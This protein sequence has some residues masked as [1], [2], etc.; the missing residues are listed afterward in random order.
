M[1]VKFKFN[2]KFIFL[3]IFA[4][5]R[6]FGLYPIKRGP[7]NKIINFLLIIW[8]F[9]HLTLVGILSFLII[10]KFLESETEIANFDNILTSSSLILTYFIVIVESLFVRNNLVKIWCHV[11]SADD[12][13]GKMIDGYD[14]ILLKFYQKSSIKIIIY[15]IITFFLELSIIFNVTSDSD[16]TFMWSVSILPLTVSRLRHLQYM[17][18][19]DV[20]TCRFRV[21]KNELKSIVVFTRIENNQLLSK[22]SAFYDG[23]YNKISGIKKVYNTLWESSLLMNKSFGISQI[24]NFLQNFVHLT[25]GFYMMYAFLNVNDMSYILGKHINGLK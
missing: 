24:A 8:S 22:N 16:W 14:Q 3:T 13:I 6:C 17:L 1:F 15:L 19:V 5:F 2:W 20:L 21:I 18:H 10:K 25:C 7:D 9:V 23:I 11:A 4:L 12:L